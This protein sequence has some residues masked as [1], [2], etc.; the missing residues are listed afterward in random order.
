[1]E[2]WKMVFNFISGSH[3][4]EL[5]AKEKEMKKSS[6][7]ME[8][9][10]DLLDCVV[11]CFP[12]DGLPSEQ[13]QRLIDDP[14]LM[15][16]SLRGMIMSVSLEEKLKDGSMSRAD[17][18]DL[19]GH[20][21]IWDPGFDELN[22]PLGDEDDEAEEYPFAGTGH[23]ALVEFERIGRKPASLRACGNY[24]K[25]NPMAQRKHLL[26]G[27]GAR[28]KIPRRNSEWFPIFG[29]IDLRGTRLVDV[30]LDHPGALFDT[31]ECRFLLQKKA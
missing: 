30:G 16:E 26:V 2:G 21:Y 24:I 8:Q 27:I 12:K 10:R 11:R 4:L 29:V 17:W 6:A 7:Q 19:F 1:M 25:A 13:V 28:R 18:Q 5:V 9:M 3:A 31:Q 15:E 20:L 23:K 14:R 22:F